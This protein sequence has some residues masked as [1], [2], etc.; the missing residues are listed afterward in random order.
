[1][2][3]ALATALGPAHAAPLRRLLV[4]TAAAAAAQGLA[5]ALLVPLLYAV[6]GSRPAGAL[7]WLAA[8]AAAVAGYGA[9]TWSAQTRAFRLGSDVARALHH[10]LG[11][12]IIELPLGWFSPARTGQLSRLAGQSVP[13]L[14]NVPAHLLR[15]VVTA[16]I[17]PAVVAVTLLVVEPR[18][19]AAVAVTVPLLAVVLRAADRA[20]ARADADRHRRADEVAARL[21]E[22]AQAQPV[23]RAYGRTAREHR[24]LDDAL[25]AQAAADRA[26]LRHV[27]PALTG[28]GFAVRALLGGVLLAGTNLVLGGSLDVPVLLAVLVLTV[29]LTEPLGTA[30][31]YGAALRLANGRL[32]TLDDVL[33]AATLPAPDQPRTPRSAEVVLDD[34]HFGYDGRP[35]LAGVSFTLPERGMTALVG[36][37]GAG[38]STVARLLAR[39][40]DVDAGAIRIGG[41]DVRQMATADLMS[42]VAFVF[43]DV[44]LFDG[45]LAGNIRLGRAD[46]TDEEVRAAAAAA[47]LGDLLDRLDDPVGEGGTALSGGQRQRVSIARALLKNAPIVVLDEATAALDPETAA[48]VQTAVHALARRTTLLVIAHRLET[49]RAADQILVLRDGVITERGRHDDLVGAGGTYA[50]FWHDRTAAEGWRLVG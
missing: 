1:M 43:Q 29:R 36:P 16:A 46:A 33:T 19:G 14:M 22:F 9:L 44:Y 3:R 12:K 6:L 18:L 13:Q 32:S 10:R 35:V 41:V 21:V 5:Y 50:S 38:K 34:V 26:M 23:L 49:V 45:T 11:E 31:E 2:I 8:F 28:F 37:S 27:I 15:P 4:L 40:W 42:R 20:V 24:L 30:A 25:V 39:F 47:G 7:P 17:T 48:A